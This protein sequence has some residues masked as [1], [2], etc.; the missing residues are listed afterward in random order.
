MRIMS[1]TKILSFSDTD[2]LAQQVEQGNL[3]KGGGFK[4]AE[5]DLYFEGLSL[6]VVDDFNHECELIYS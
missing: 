3:R 5:T 6:Y 2:W 4:H 1:G